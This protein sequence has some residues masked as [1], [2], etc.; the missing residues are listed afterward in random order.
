MNENEHEVV[1]MIGHKRKKIVAKIPL[2]YEVHL[3]IDDLESFIVPDCFRVDLYKRPATRIGSVNDYK[4]KADNIRLIFKKMRENGGNFPFFLTYIQTIHSVL[5][6]VCEM[7]FF[8]RRR[9]G[10]KTL[11]RH[12]TEKEMSVFL[13]ME[14]PLSFF[15]IPK[16]KR[17]AKN[18]KEMR[19]SSKKITES[20][21]SKCALDEYFN[22][23]EKEI[24]VYEFY[25]KKLQFLKMGS[26]IR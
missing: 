1:K 18:I 15:T 12:L 17:I 21:S 16:I 3:I 8:E 9:A 13:I 26:W 6:S 4:R 7:K 25:F 24:E 19:A 22:T 20:A 10:L 2:P 14:K 11:S 23:I 5:K